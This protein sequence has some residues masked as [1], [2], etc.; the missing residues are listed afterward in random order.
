MSDI[1]KM[2]LSPEM[3]TAISQT[4]S[5]EIKRPLIKEEIV[6]IANRIKS[7]DHRWLD[8][9]DLTTAAR[10]VAA[11]IVSDFKQSYIHTEDIHEHLN[12]TIGD[13]DDTNIS[14]RSVNFDRVDRSMVK[15]PEET[16]Y[17]KIGELLGSSNV[18]DFI[19][20]I[21]PDAVTAVVQTYLDS[22]NRNITNYDNIISYEWI[23]VQSQNYMR[24]GTT[25]VAD[26]VRDIVSFKIHK[27]WIPL[28]TIGSPT[29]LQLLSQ[30]N[31]VS[32]SISGYDAR[33]PIIPYTKF[34]YQ[35]LFKPTV[36]GNRIELEPINDEYKFDQPITELSR[37]SITFG[38]PHLPITF[39]QDR[40]QLVLPPSYNFTTVGGV[41]ESSGVNLLINVA[42]TLAVNDIVYFEGFNTGRASDSAKIAEINRTSGHVVVAATANQFTLNIDIS[43]LLPLAAD[44][45]AYTVICYFG[46]KRV[47]IPLDIKYLV[48]R[49]VGTDKRY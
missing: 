44:I 45:S 34:V 35:F 47:E 36:S 37:F 13:T 2:L 21:N 8:S 16:P 26:A 31:R 32:M 42:N 41:M 46:S 43:G 30:Y 4:V 15:L 14:R 12:S 28:S 1:R 27:F 3:L 48:S 11:S 24:Q 9:Q 38:S 33:S 29:L 7:L 23:P 25:L 18:Y 20:K 6:S 40:A 49:Y 39:N 17:T 5:D 22:R 19:R 10:A